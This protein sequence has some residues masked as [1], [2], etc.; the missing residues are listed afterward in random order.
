MNAVTIQ[1]AAELQVITVAY[2][3]GWSDKIFQSAVIVR[4]PAQVSDII[5]AWAGKDTEFGTLLDW[6]V[7]TY[8]VAPF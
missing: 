3:Y 4:E 1:P 8:A 2:S 6:R 7:D 5:H